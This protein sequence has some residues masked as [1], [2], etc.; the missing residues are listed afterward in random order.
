[1]LVNK[2]LLEN[3]LEGLKSGAGNY[4]EK[5]FYL[6]ILAARVKVLSKYVNYIVSSWLLAEDLL[7]DVNVHEVYRTGKH[8]DLSHA[9]FQLLTLVMK[10][11]HRIIKCEDL[12]YTVWQV[13]PLDGDALCAHLS[14][15]RQ[16]IN[17]S[18]DWLLLYTIRS[19]RYKLTD[20]NAND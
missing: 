12:E 19:I 9:L 7:L 1:M 2:D 20:K 17:K 11:P 3:K 10:N 8:I 4:L 18:S 5:L 13:G 16:V 14:N 15:L 6:I